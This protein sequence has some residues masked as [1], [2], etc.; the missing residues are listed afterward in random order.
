MNR[1]SM[2]SAARD[3]RTWDVLV[4]GGG[5]TGL[6]TAV[7]AAARGYHTLL[8]EAGDFAHG[9]SSRSTKLVHGGV[10]YLQQ[11]DIGLVMEAL[12]ERGRLLKNAPQLVH[13]RAFVVP[14]YDWWEGPFYG[15]G[16]KLY[17][18]LA[19]KLGIGPSQWLSL[20]E[21]RERIPTIEPGGLRGGVIYHDGQFDDARLAVT[22][23]RTAADLGATVL[24]YARVEALRKDEGRIRGATVL[25]AESGESFDVDA[26]VVVNATGAFSDQ[27][28]RMDRS[29]ARD[30]IRPSQGVHIVLDRSFLPGD[31][32]IMVPHTDDGRVL[33]AVPWHGRIIVGTTDT[34]LDEA[35]LEPRP[36]DEEIEFLLEH[37]VRYLT[38]NPTR[39]DIL[40]T[41]AGIRP[42]VV[43]G[44]DDDDEGTAETGSASDGARKPSDTASI[45]RDHHLSVSDSGLVTIAGGKWTTYR[46]MAED[47]IDRA[48][49]VGGLERRDCPTEELHLR[50]WTEGADPADPLS[51]Y[52]TDAQDVLDLS[53]GDLAARLHPRLPY[54]RAEVVWAARHEMAR[55]VDD[56]LSRRTRALLLDARAACEAADDAARLLAGEIGRDAAWA[57]H[58]AAAFRD[59]AAGY[60]P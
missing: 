22:L 11:G 4:V 33:F 52:G 43:A 46:K 51:V 5:A 30:I 29:G 32:A 37:S 14:V 21:T 17:D 39:D 38:G 12:R 20:E 35:V 8:V 50:G 6:G 34:P 16:L 55:T 26:R 57:E 1:D 53:A 19:G 36:R 31:S 49:E 59:T 42:L 28:R 47:T 58:Q 10:R 2:L 48:A 25:D 7:D 9:T 45:S 27:V 54:R 41:F 60:L 40:S 23:A 24:N 3:G 13:N 56:V 15:I 18:V 44:G